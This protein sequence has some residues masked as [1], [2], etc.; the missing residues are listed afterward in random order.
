MNTFHF[1]GCLGSFTLKRH[2][3]RTLCSVFLYSFVINF[4]Y[5]KKY[6]QYLKNTVTV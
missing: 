3:T 6:N 4:L 1:A 2:Q 5:H